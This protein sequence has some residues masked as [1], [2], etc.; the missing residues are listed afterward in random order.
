MKHYMAYGGIHQKVS[1][2][3]RRVR[4]APAR[5]RPEPGLRPAPQDPADVQVISSLGKRTGGT[6]PMI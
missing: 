2:Q 3:R 1:P 4:R 6:A 5:P